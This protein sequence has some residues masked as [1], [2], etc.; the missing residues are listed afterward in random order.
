MT[1]RP[2]D[3]STPGSP[4]VTQAPSTRAPG[5]QTIGAYRLLERVGEGGMGEVWLAEQ[6][7]PVHRQVA[8]KV[9]K[10]GSRDITELL[11][12]LDDILGVQANVCRNGHDAGDRPEEVSGGARVQSSTNSSHIPYRLICAGLLL[13][14]RQSNGCRASR[15]KGERRST[16]HGRP[17]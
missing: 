12:A 11:D 10:A 7:R 8:L 15:G 14:R 16:T 5:T 2:S 17:D 1:D 3:S 9:I 6:A 13:G 4:D